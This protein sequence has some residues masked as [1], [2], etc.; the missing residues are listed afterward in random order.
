MIL[1]KR[2]LFVDDENAI[3][4]TLRF[5]LQ[6]YGFSVIPA[7]TVREALHQIEKQEFDFLPCDLN[8]ERE[9]DGYDVIRAMQKKQ[10][11]CET[12][13]LTGYPTMNSA[14]EGIRLHIDDYLVK[15][16]SV[17]SLVALLADKLA[18]RHLDGPKLGDNPLRAEA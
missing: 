5:I 17:D 1:R 11:R 9:G 15:P 16:A 3:R 8:I 7:A 4:E 6:R 2:L 13:V 10:P 12:I 14:I 18:K